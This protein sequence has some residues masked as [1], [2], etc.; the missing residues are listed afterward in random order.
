VP[1]YYEILK[2]SPTAVAAE[3]QSACEAQRAQ[4]ERFVNHPDAQIANKARQGVQFLQKVFVTLS[5]AEKRRAYDA[6]IGLVAGLADPHAVPQ[7][8]ACVPPP[9]KLAI[10]EPLPKLAS[11]TNTPVDA[12][13]C[14][15]CQ[16]RNPIGSR[17]CKDCRQVLAYECPQCDELVENT[18]TFCSV[19]GFDLKGYTQPLVLKTLLT[20]IDDK[21]AAKI[22]DYQKKTSWR[23]RLETEEV[24][25]AI[26][27][28]FLIS[29][30]MVKNDFRTQFSIAV[31]CEQAIKVHVNSDSTWLSVD[32][33]ELTLEANK[34][35]IVRV[36]LDVG[37]LERGQVHTGVI[38]FTTVNANP[39]I[40]K[41]YVMLGVKKFLGDSDAKAELASTVPAQLESIFLGPAFVNGMIREARQAAKDND[42]LKRAAAYASAVRFLANPRTDPTI[43]IPPLQGIIA[44]DKRASAALAPTC[45]STCN[46]R[47]FITWFRVVKLGPSSSLDGAYTI[48]LSASLGG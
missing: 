23:G 35:H 32:R 10:T 27:R 44:P 22:K 47:S 14:P 19:C 20:D 18:A 29:L 2:V 1:T 41:H 6:S 24:G 25:I 46:H 39:A 37:N 21:L 31:Q 43:V 42:P 11:A 9:T 13:V 45:V 15:K 5:D 4:L 12:W 34:N 38:T 17:R 40:A 33:T 30:G 26:W 28:N 16:S 3:I 36:N 48:P 7:L 8:E